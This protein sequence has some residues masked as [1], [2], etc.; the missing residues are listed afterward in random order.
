MALFWLIN[1]SAKP[2]MSPIVRCLF[3]CLSVNFNIKDYF[4]IST[5]LISTRFDT[6]HLPVCKGTQCFFQRKTAFFSKDRYKPNRK[7]TTLTFMN[8]L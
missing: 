2:F 1:S 8:F 4:S 3:V 7:K 5:S 6:K